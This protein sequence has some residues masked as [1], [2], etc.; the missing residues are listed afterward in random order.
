[1]WHMA[2]GA[3][4]ASEYLTIP[5]LNRIKTYAEGRSM[6]IPAILRRVYGRAPV[7]I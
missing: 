3:S 5:T 7:I 4:G 2:I 6:E 1:M